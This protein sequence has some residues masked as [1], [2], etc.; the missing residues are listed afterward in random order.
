LITIGPTDYLANDEQHSQ[1]KEKDKLFEEQEGNFKFKEK[2]QE[3][4]R[5]GKAL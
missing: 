1:L 5:L 3:D 2:K 4:G